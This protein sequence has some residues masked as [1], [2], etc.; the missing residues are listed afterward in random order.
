M[1]RDNDLNKDYFI[2]LMLA[3]AEQ[4]SSTQQKAGDYLASQG[5]DPEQI[6]NAGLEK[7]RAL[8]RHLSGYA[9]RSVPSP[10]HQR[11]WTHKS[12]IRLISETGNPDPVDAIRSRA[13]DLVV[14]AFSKG[15]QGPPY[16]PIELAQYMGIEVTPQDSVVDA[17]TFQTS[18]GC[19]IE[20]NPVQRPTRRNFS[21]AHEIAH[22]LFSDWPEEIRN[23]EQEPVENRELEQL[24]N[25]AAAEIQLPYG[26]FSS[27]A[28]HVPA[29]MP[30]LIELAKR[31]QASLE[32][33]FIRYTEV[34][35]KPCAILIGTFQTDN[36]IVIDYYKASR[37]LPLRLPD[38]IEIPQDSK[39]YECSSGGWTSSEPAEWSVFKEKG[40]S[41][42]TIGISPY[43]KDN[44]PR[45]G[46]LVIPTIYAAQPPE[47]GK[48][49]L[50][51]G[52]A[53]Q[54]RGK[55]KRIIAQVV[56]SYGA[57]GAGF[58][59]AMAMRYPVT[60]EKLL[61]WKA[62]K[63]AFILGNSQIFPVGEGIYVF[64]MLTQIGI[65]PKPGS[66]SLQ[67]PELRK[68]LI[69][70]R[71][72]ARELKASVHMP[73]IGSGQAGG[74]WQIIIGMIHDELV[75]YDIKVSVYFLPGKPFNPKLKSHLT[76]FKEDSTWG[77]GK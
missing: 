57:V 70:L 6:E 11:R 56:N 60:K 71:N 61:E 23:R 45:V 37:S 28:N 25:A 5:A 43:R 65:M 66:I 41:A 67:Y 1:T 49:V 72:K 52:D 10:L 64:Q 33:V 74:E 8:Q 76:I 50:E 29:S 38:H 62:N 12:V 47:K 20:Y 26:I 17:R 51:Y 63:K 42:F 31:Y 3:E 22:T 18:R 24:C 21:V 4:V 34:I 19:L 68:C 58:G 35:D 36:R 46:I 59:K 13:R 15:W 75:N 2:R 39:A 55:G 9:D 48:I 54:P 73:A 40:Y 32:S 53:T 16:S 44:K 30:N 77:T 27:D 69:E 14:R 7:I